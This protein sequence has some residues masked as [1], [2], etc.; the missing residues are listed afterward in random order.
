MPENQMRTQEL[1]AQEGLES[2][3]QKLYNN[4]NI[5]LS[6]DP[7]SARRWIWELLQ[8]AKDVII[9]DGQIEINLTDSA[10]EFSHNGSPFQHSNLLA[11][12]SQRSTKAP[13]YTD[14]EKQTF[15]DR[16]FSEEGINND[17]AKKFLNTSGR[18]GTGF[19]TT[20]LLSKKISLE[21]IYTTSDRIK[22][23][24]IS[25]DREAETPDQMKEKVKKSFASFTE[26]EQSN[27]TE[28]NISDYKE[29]SK[30][31]TKFVYEYDA[32]GKKIAEIGIADLHKSIPFT[33]SFV[34]KINSVKVIEYGKVTTY[35]RLKPLT[36]NSVSIVRIEKETENDKALIEIAKV[37]EKHDALTISIPVENIGESKYKIL[38]PNEAT[39]RKFISFP[40][41]GSETFPFPVIINSPLFN[42]ADDT[43][44]SVSLNLSGSFQYDKKVHLNRAIFEKSIGLYKQLLSFASE[45]NWENIHYLAKSDLPIDVDKI[46]YQQNIQQEIRKEILDADIVATEHCTTRIKPKDAKF[47][48]YKSDK[49]DEFWALCQYLIGD[50]IPRK[51]DVEIW[52]NII[53]ANTESWLGADFDFTLEK[54]LLLIQDEGTFTEFSKKYFSNNEEAFSALNKIIQFAEDENKE[55]L[56]RKENPLKVF[57][58]QTPESIFR[59][60]RDLSRDINV[61]FQ[62]KN[63]LR[64]TGDNWYEK[65]VRNEIT[66]FERES[67]LTI[68]HASDIIKDKIEK[69]FSGKLKEEEEIQLSEGLFELIGY[70]FADSETDFETLHTFAARIFPDKVNDKLEEITVSNDFDYKPCQ[71][72]AIKT[73]LKKVSELVDLNS[74]SQDLFN[75]SYPEVKDEYSDAEK[76]Q[77]YPVD[78]FLNDLIQFAIEFENNQY[79]LLSEYAII[80]NQLNELCKFNN[81]IF[82]DDNIPVEL[83]NILKDFGVECRRNLLH[84]GV[85]VK[86]NDNRDLKWIC[87]QLDDVVIKEQNNDSFKQP[88]RELDK[89]ISAQKETITR[90]DELFKSFNRKRSGIVLNTYG[91]EERNQFDEILKS[92][93]SAD[94]ADIVKSGAKAETI[95]ELAII[96]KDINLESALSILKDHP[97]LTSEK[98]ERLLELEELSKGWNP[99]LSYNPDEEQTRRNFENGWKGEAFVYKELRKKNF[100]VDWVNLSKTENNNFI[101]DFEGEKHYIVDTGGKYDLKAKLSNGNTIY[102]QVKATITDISN[103]DHIAMPISTREWKFVFETNDNEAY[104]LARVFNVNEKDPELY[105]M[106]L[107]K[108]QEL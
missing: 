73:I 1:L 107:E 65:L 62:I 50:N 29:G 92:G 103:A 32:E 21:S 99:E 12:L 36:F 52:K 80:P 84:N 25:L 53:E 55:L 42:P 40:L 54:L 70:S 24:V 16:L 82:N 14:D 18:F 19:M 9:D 66:I 13:S 56:D 100:E 74:L 27:D 63:L 88:I 89:W 77:M 22:S 69:S 11:I 23:F 5:E 17:D 59:E 96:S 60:K 30:C 35:T 28:N 85:S 4:I 97:E 44:S 58:D 83:K 20:Y 51:D 7:Q 72:W 86:L 104:Y 48:I 57:P 93:M 8:N 6:G 3:G 38:F 67:K 95:K 81:E 64:T 47:P 34:E 68:K 10:V 71:L 106:K 31:Y 105:F 75:A 61:P 108:P 37:S 87:S 94:F 26:L 79:H 33:L 76:D 2:I 15:F 45:K 98:I 78:V 91:L 102:I 46:W 39:P 41:V 43:R 49:L 90:M 101:I